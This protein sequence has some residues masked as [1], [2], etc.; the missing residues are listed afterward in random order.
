MEQWLVRK[1]ACKEVA[2]AKKRDRARQ[3]ALLMETLAE[4]D[5]TE[6]MQ[7]EEKEARSKAVREAVAN[8]PCAFCGKVSFET[9]T[10]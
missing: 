8:P 5:D 1:T 10:N 4:E 3:E 7:S 6:K 9:C 2:A